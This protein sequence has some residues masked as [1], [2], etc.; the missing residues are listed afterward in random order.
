MDEGR[1]TNDERLQ[2]RPSSFVFRRLSLIS[3]FLLRDIN[4]HP[5]DIANA[6]RGIGDRLG[7][8]VARVIGW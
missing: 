4:Q 2:F 1:K 3:P 7:V 5:C 8:L 6:E